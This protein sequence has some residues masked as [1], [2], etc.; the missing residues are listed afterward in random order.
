MGSKVDDYYS[1]AKKW[2]DELGTLRSIVLDSGLNE[3]LKWGKPCYTLNDGNVVIVL[4][5]KEYCA[6]M[7]L[8]GALLADTK[9]LLIAAG[10]NSQSARQMRFTSVG[11]IEKSTRTIKSY[12]KEA[13]ALEKAGA[14]VPTKKISERD[15]PDEFKAKLAKSAALKQAFSA[16]TPGRQRA[17]LMHFAGAKQAKT[18]E[19]RIE[20]WIPQILAGKGL[21]D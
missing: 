2:R 4:G 6:L 15:V 9:K 13:I 18:R 21:D 10:E 8:K 20:K 1:K 7:F 16:L 12:L 3:D 19:S 14:K 5:F 17:Y 11:A